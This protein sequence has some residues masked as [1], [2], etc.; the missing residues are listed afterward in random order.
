MRPDAV[1]AFGNAAR[2]GLV[3]CEHDAQAKLVRL[4]LA[5]AVRVVAREVHVLGRS[6]H[7]LLHVRDVVRV[8]R[9]ERVG[10][11]VVAVQ[12]HVHHAVVC[13]VGGVRVAAVA[14]CA[15]LLRRTPGE[16][17]LG[18]R[19]VQ[20]RHAVLAR[21]E[22]LV[23]VVV[24]A[25]RLVLEAHHDGKERERGAR[26][27]GGAS[28]QLLRRGRGGRTLGLLHLGHGDRCGRRRVASGLA[29]VGV[30][31]QP[32][33]RRAGRVAGKRVRADGAGV[34]GGLRVRAKREA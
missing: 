33:V 24:V 20:R 23:P 16:L 4:D 21:E 31:A 17:A 34:R 10:V 12:R 13:P 14:V 18:G 11:A 2:R 1:V 30:T 7:G 15:G 27:G 29:G 28:H 5:V 22:R 9:R 32:V 6:L 26:L 8:A 19:G 3:A 25:V